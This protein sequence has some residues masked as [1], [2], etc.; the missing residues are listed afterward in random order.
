MLYNTGFHFML[1]P[2]L[3]EY[4]ANITSLTEKQ[5]HFWHQL[6]SKLKHTD[7]V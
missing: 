3:V 2:P 4:N 1:I 5:S 6:H 7:F